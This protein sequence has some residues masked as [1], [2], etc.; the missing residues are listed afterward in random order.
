M[1]KII[2][3]IIITGIHILCIPIIKVYE[4]FFKK[5]SLRVL[6]YHDI[7]T[8]DFNDF[9]R[10]IRHIKKKYRFIDIDEFE[11]ILGGSTKPRENLVLLTFDDGFESNYHVANQVLSNH[12]IKAVFF[13]AVDFLQTYDMVGNSASEFI[14]NN[15]KVKQHINSISLNCDQILRLSSLGHV[16]G[17]HSCSHNDLS[18]ISK[19]KIEHEVIDSKNTLEKILNLKVNHFAYP[20]GG[21]NNINS[22]SLK[23]IKDKYKHCHT[24]IRGNNLKYNNFIIFR[25]EISP[26]YNLL[27]LSALLSGFFDFIYYWKRSKVIDFINK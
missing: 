21:I 26:S 23:V 10:Q 27:Y 6:L 17:S 2:L 15:F 16:F 22:Y 3:K 25:D 1:Y 8:A 24:G 11:Q 18:Q 9:E 4:I 13:I 14:L 5:Y 12:G 7:Q 20:F 19:E